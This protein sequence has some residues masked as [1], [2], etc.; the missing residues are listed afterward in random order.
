MAKTPS[1]IYA[2]DC[3]VCKFLGHLDDGKDALADL[4]F[5]DE[6]GMPTVIARFG[7]GSDYVSGIEFV[8]KVGSITEAYRRAIELG[9][10]RR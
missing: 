5:C 10:V 8:G 6:T 2:H 4:Y 7:K 3:D 1:P 9:F